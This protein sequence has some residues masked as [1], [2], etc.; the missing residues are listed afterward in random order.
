MIN[1][2]LTNSTADEYR[3]KHDEVLEVR[4]EHRL[5][6]NWPIARAAYVMVL[7]YARDWNLFLSYR[8][9][10][11]L[12]KSMHSAMAFR[13]RSL[14]LFRPPIG[15]VRSIGRLRGLATVSEGTQYE[16]SPRSCMFKLTTLLSREQSV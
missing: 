4:A 14:A 6:R 16:I 11:V 7:I 2:E 10:L 9:S 5:P 1:L 13:A 12:R 3:E 8:T 15:S